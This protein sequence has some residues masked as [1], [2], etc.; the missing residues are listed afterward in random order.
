METFILGVD[1][2]GTTCRAIL[3]D[4]NGKLLSHCEGGPANPKA[5]GWQETR[6]VL[7][8]LSVKVWKAA[9]LEP[10]PATAAF[11]GLAGLRLPLEQ[12]SYREYL[13]PLRLA[14]PDKVQCDHD[15]RIAH[16]GGLL[17][18]EGVVLVAGTGSAAYARDKHGK[19]ARVGGWGWLID[20]AGSTCWMGM[21]AI[22]AV[23]RAADHRGPET[24]LTDIINREWGQESPDELPVNFYKTPLPREWVS[25]LAP[26][27]FS[28]A[29]AGDTVAASIIDRGAEELADLAASAARRLNFGERIP[30]I[31]NGGLVKAGDAFLK[32]LNAALARYLPNGFITS[33]QLPAVF[34][35]ALLG[36]KLAEIEPS[37]ETLAN[38]RQSASAFCTN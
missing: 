12:E 32:P 28:A 14:A 1:G 4:G 18:K 15:L 8:E 27:V 20:D 36:L 26:M 38:L 17:G 11:L 24:T 10:R 19:A 21:E 37:A 33:P 25:K 31:V 16:E 6:N 9:G 29:I 3:V 13:N 22:R 35:A 34:G 23:A 5:A 7:S 2:G 30:V